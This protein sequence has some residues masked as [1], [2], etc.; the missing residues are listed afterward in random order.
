MPYQVAIP[1]E[2]EI[3]FARGGAGWTDAGPLSLSRHPQRVRIAGCPVHFTPSEFRLLECLVSWHGAIAPKDLI[4]DRISCGGERLGA[5][6]FDDHLHSIRRKIRA[7]IGR[8]CI[9]FLPESGYLLFDFAPETHAV[10][11]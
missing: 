10:P 11:H 6:H 9:H 3:E 4:L 8:D 1:V 7:A 2:E 5:T